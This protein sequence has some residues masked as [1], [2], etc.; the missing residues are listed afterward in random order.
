LTGPNLFLERLNN[1][2][3]NKVFST[4]YKIFNP[5]KESIQNIASYDGLK[6]GRFDGAY[7]YDFT[8]LNTQN[9]LE[10]RKKKYLTFLSTNISFFNPLINKYLNRFSKALERNVELIIYQSEISKFQQEKYVVKTKKP[11]TIINNG[12]PLDLF[13][14]KNKTVSNNLNLVITANFRPHKRLLD[15]ILLTNRL[16]SKFP[17][18]RL[19]I[20]GQ[21]DI[22]SFEEVKKHDLSRC[23]FLGSIDS[24][25]IHKIYSEC[26]IGLSPSLFDP[27]P[28]SV[29]EMMACGLPVIT[30]AESGA[31]E[32][33]GISKLCIPENLKL[34]FLE[35]QTIEK[36]P[37]IDIGRWIELIIEILEN[38]QEYQNKIQEQ[39]ENRLDIRV[40]ARKYENFIKFHLETKN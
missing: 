8:K 2:L 23:D 30:C 25:E 34:D 31:S 17:N 38:Y 27:C 39:V 10:L 32:L 36:L 6:I 29:A 40:V 26:H 33:I 20:I 35:F 9:F 21:L 5:T 19:K 12:V 22:I 16:S 24:Y 37:K 3:I 11:T 7:F 28:N 14:F 15:A 4:H 13:P 1:E 18:V